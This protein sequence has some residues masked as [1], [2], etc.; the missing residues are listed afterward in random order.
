MP[1]G[2]LAGGV[3]PTLGGPDELRSPRECRGQV[4]DVQH[5]EALGQRPAAPPLPPQP[6]QFIL[7]K[8]AVHG[9]ERVITERS[10]RINRPFPPAG[11]QVGVI[12]RLLAGMRAIKQFCPETS[13]E[14]MRARSLKLSRA[15]TAAGA[16]TSSY[17]VSICY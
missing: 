16:S 4:Q 5:V 7:G 9:H 2:R 3:R 11:T 17:L 15:R 8:R 13:R 14:F 12:E 6:G 10:G 1:A